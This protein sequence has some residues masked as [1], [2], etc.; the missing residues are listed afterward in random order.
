MKLE[1]NIGKT[2]LSIGIGN[3]L[4]DMTPKHKQQKQNSAAK[5]HTTQFKN[6]QITC[7]TIS[8]KKTQK[9]TMSR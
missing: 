9:W 4:L 3:G 5:R 8:P 6:G 2:L 1:E 7:L